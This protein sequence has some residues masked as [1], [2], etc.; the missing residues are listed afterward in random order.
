MFRVAKQF[1]SAASICWYPVSDYA[2]RRFSIFRPIHSN[3]TRAM[4][5]TEN[6]NR[7]AHLRL[8]NTPQ[9]YGLVAI[10]LHWL[11]LVAVVS[12]FTLGVWMTG[13]SYYDEWYKKGPDL[14]RSI[15]VL[16]F[17]ALL[18][19]VVWRITNVTPEQEPGMARWQVLL[20]HGIHMLLYV[21]LF[22]MVISGYLISTADGRPVDVFG[23]FQ[24]PAVIDLNIENLEDKAG[25]VHWYLAL[26][27]AGFI[28]VHAL[29]AFKHH[30]IDRDRTLNKMLGIRP[31]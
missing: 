25:A 20:A 26:V 1:I 12:L 13:L 30:F 9:S 14:H 16:L 4:P 2:A 22:A 8:T 31:K 18:F 23:W 15:G 24:I 7:S 5:A 29:A 11:F 28:A 27:M 3:V 19:R 17:I 21:L 6:T 10:M